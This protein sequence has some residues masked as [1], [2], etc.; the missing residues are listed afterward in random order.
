MGNP[1]TDKGFV[2][3]LDDRLTKVYQNKY[4]GL[5]LIIDKFF[6]RKKSKKAWEEYFSVGSVPDP[7]LFQGIIQYQ[8]VSPGYHTK[9]TPMEYAGGITIQRR[10]IDT[11]RYDVI[12]N[13]SKGLA[14]AANRKMN[15]IAHQVFQNFDSTAFDFMT[16]E[17]GVALCSNSHTTKAPDVSTASGFDNLSTLA[18]DAT[19]LE[20]LRLQSKGLRD[21]IG[22]R[23][24]TNF[25]TIIHG[26]NLAADVW[27]VLNSQGKTGDNLNNENFQRGR[28]KSIELP[29][30]D[31]TD[32]NDWFIVDSALMKES[33]IWL[34]GVPVEF[35]STTDFD[36]QMRKYADYFVVGWGFVDFRWIVG[37]SVS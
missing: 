28:W 25:D 31:D 35:N 27:E 16:S 26:T 14:V 9:I 13:M 30:L 8:G 7:E 2:R 34:D 6:D 5:P 29:M 24:E 32:T 22:E 36:T 11:D 18:F 15:K 3:L 19:N 1:L 33:L 4:K 23:I 17:E 12:E 10:L 37:S 21:D 20:A